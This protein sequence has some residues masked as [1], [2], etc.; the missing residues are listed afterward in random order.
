MIVIDVTIKRVTELNVSRRGQNQ[1]GPSYFIYKCANVA[2]MGFL[3]HLP[4]L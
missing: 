2:L 1:Q 3:R 4:F